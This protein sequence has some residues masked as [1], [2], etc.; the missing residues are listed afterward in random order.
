MYNLLADEYDDA[1]CAEPTGNQEVVSGN[2]LSAGIGDGECSKAGTV[3]VLTECLADGAIIL[4]MFGE[5]DST[6]S[7]DVFIESTSSAGATGTCDSL[8]L[9]GHYYK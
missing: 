8:K 6:C 9:D 3:Y 1:D 7:G 2:V 4:Q 5:D